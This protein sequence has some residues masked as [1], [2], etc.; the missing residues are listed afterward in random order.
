VKHVKAPGAYDPSDLI[1]FL[2][3]SIEMGAA[4]NWQ[5]LFADAM[6]W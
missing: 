2:G 6:K 4:E 5:D 3:G 1:I